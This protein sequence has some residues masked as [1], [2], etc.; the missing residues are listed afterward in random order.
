MNTYNR[1][2]SGHAFYYPAHVGPGDEWYVSSVVDAAY[3]DTSDGKSWIGAVGTI[4]EAVNLAANG[5]TIWVAPE[6]AET[7]TGGTDIAMDVAGVA[8]IGIVR[9]RQMPTVNIAHVTST[10]AISGANCTLANIRITGGIDAIVATITASAAD[11]AII[12]CEFRDVTGQ[13]TDSILTTNGADRLLIDGYR[14]IGSTTDGPNSAIAIV[15]GDYAIIRNCDI[16]G[17]F[18]VACI[19]IR[20]TAAVWLRIYDCK[21][22]NEDATTSA[23]GIQCIMDTITS[24]TGVFGPN[25]AMVLGYDAANVTN[26]A[27]WDGAYGDLRGCTVMNAA[28][29]DGLEINWTAV[30]DS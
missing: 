3:G 28:A 29:Q 2:S 23:D 13:A 12:N 20:T 19:D 8:V 15:G 7:I 11:C 6:H 21:L 14:H 25:V 17:D 10:I 18:A 30:V 16:F 26:A 5:D 4:D 9:G 1:W 27:F 24:S 22:K